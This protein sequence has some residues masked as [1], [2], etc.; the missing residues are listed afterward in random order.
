MSDKKKDKKPSIKK[1]VSRP[2]NKKLRARK[3]IEARIP[4]TKT[5]QEPVEIKQEINPEK[6]TIDLPDGYSFERFKQLIDFSVD[7]LRK[8]AEQSEE[9][10][11]HKDML[12]A[13]PYIFGAELAVSKQ[14]IPESERPVVNFL[15]GKKPSEVAEADRKDAL[16]AR[17]RDMKYNRVVQ[18]SSIVPEEKKL[19]WFKKFINLFIR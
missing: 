15:K 6:I 17:V 18:Q 3:Q 10:A 13:I 2:A 1:Q 8:I 16:V 4:Q 14:E 19:N 7:E 11:K 9:T 5:L 12:R